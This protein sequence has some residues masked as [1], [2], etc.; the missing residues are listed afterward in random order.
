MAS[1]DRP[2]PR[3][4]EPDT[5]PFWEATR[6]HELRYQAC[7]KCSAVV[8][9]PR[10]HCTHCLSLALTWKLSG[11]EGVIYTYSI[12]RQTYDP[13]FAPLVPYV[14]AWIDLDEGFRMLSNVVGAAP[15]AVHIGQR[16]QVQWL[17]YEEVSLP[18]FRPL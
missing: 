14:I 7:D 3:F 17:D 1:R 6:N 4:P 12:V 15:E 5:Q 8:F 2:L 16:V 11:G 10:R 18:V 9:Y 13:A